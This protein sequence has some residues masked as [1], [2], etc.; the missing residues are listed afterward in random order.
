MIGAAERDLVMGTARGG[1][2]YQ[3]RY[4][5]PISLDLGRSAMVLVFLVGRVW[6]I[7]AVRGA[8]MTVV[9]S[10]RRWKTVAGTR[11]LKNFGWIA[12]VRVVGVEKFELTRRCCRLVALL[13][14]MGFLAPS[15]CVSQLPEKP[16]TSQHSD[17]PAH[18]SSTIQPA[19]EAQ[20][21]FL[22]SSGT[23]APS[24]ADRESAS[25][26]GIP[27]GFRRVLAIIEWHL[28]RGL[29]TFAIP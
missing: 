23:G 18:S 2:C 29:S 22:S 1:S 12:G 24:P 5:R 13:A 9:W 4:W 26:S 21:L 28:L 14:K 11:W 7:R 15:P 6:V 20:E 25:A 27:Q 3:L 17:T 16:C 10:Y 19:V 8:W